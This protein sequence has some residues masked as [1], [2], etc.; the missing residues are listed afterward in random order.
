MKA[1]Y[2]QKGETLDYIN[3]TENEIEAGDVVTIGKR[4]GVAGTQIKP[5][6]LGAVH[7][8]GV[9][10]FD[11]KDKAAMT[12]GTE[13]YLAGNGITS[14]AESNVY[15]GFVAEDSPAECTKVCVKINI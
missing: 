2:V 13:V 12:I 10:R 5:G 4:I 8:D 6:E 3:S 11:K 7:V 15:A 14:T 1:K 9:Y